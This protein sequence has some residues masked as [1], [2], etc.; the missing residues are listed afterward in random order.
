MGDWTLLHWLALMERELLLF[1]GVFFLIGALDELLVDGLFGWLKLSG[2]AK[3]LVVDREDLRCRHLAGTAAVFI[4]AWREDRVIGHTIA[5]A[6]QAW[7]QADYVIYV[8]IY[9]NDTAT[10]ESAMRGAGTDRRVRLV[11][12]D[13]DGP[14]TKADCLNRLY[15]A[16]EVDETRR[17][18]PARLVLLHDAEDMVDAAELALID[19]AVDHAEFVQIPVLPLP[20]PQSR[21]IGSHY[22]EEFAEAH[23]KTMVVRNWLGTCLPAAGVGC[24]IERGMLH[25]LAQQMRRADPGSPSPGPFSVESLTEDYEIGM[26]VHALGGRSR[27]LRV[28]G[29]DGSL[30]ATRAFFPARLDQAVRQKARWVHGIALQGWDRLGWGTGSGTAPE[31]RPVTGMGRLLEGWMRLRDRRGPFA[32]LVLACGYS[33]FALTALFLLL[34]FGG[35]SRPWQADPLLTFLVSANLAAF[36]WRAA[37]R[38][39]FTAREHGWIEGVRAVLRIPVANVIAIM[40]GR[41]ALADYWR[42]LRGGALHWHKTLHDIHPAAPLDAA[43]KP[44]APAH[45]RNGAM[46]GR[47]FA[48]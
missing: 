22:C 19:R 39:A 47:G 40:A 42:Q 10:L 14:S 30:I 29:D 4:P 45:W 9:R 12:H 2:H 3:R 1:A 26:R 48:A 44:L 6:L 27:F 23:G 37:W 13:C 43:E 36:I 21:W 31:A 17:G 25:R 28:H 15:R 8:G 46:S 33:F 32:A 38:F 35:L 7:P 5:H 41:R 24:A 11:V 34:D 16:L 18:R 20:Q